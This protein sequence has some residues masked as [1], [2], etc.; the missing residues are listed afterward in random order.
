MCVCVQYAD[1]MCSYMMLSYNVQDIIV[2]IYIYSVYTLQKI[3]QSGKR[4]QVYT[5]MYDSIVYI[6]MYIYIFE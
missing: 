3:L 4:T 6:Y 1:A 2:C 5:L